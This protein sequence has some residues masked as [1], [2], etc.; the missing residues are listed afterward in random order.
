MR[1]MRTPLRRVKIVPRVIGLLKALLPAHTVQPVSGL[2]PVRELV[3]IAVPV[4]IA[5]TVSE[6]LAVRARI[7]RR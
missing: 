5:K 6:H 4:I 2:P 3:Q 1:K 7:L